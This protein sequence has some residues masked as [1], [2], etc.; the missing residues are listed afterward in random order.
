VGEPLV[1]VDLFSGPGGF[2]RG[3]K[4]AGWVTAVAVEKVATCV[5]TYRLNFPAVPVIGRD[6]REVT[7]GEVAGHLPMAAGRRREADL[8]TAGFPCETNS[9]AGTKSR[10]TYDHRLWLYRDAIRIARAVRA[11]SLLF[12]NV[13][14]IRTKKASEGRP[15]LLIDE[16]RRDLA[17]AGYANRSEFVLTASDFGV[18]QRRER[19]FLIAARE[20]G[21]IVVPEPPRILTTVRQA[22]ADLPPD[23]PSSEYLDTASRYSRLMRD[24]G[25]WRA[26]GGAHVL[27]QHHGPRHRPSTVARN[28]LVPRGRR[29]WDLYAEL[30]PGTLAG[31]QA[32]GVLPEVPFKQRGNRLALSRPSKTVTSHCEGELLHPT[33][34]RCLSVREAAR[35]QSFPDCHIFAGPTCTAHEGQAQDMYEQVGDAVPPLVAWSLGMAMRRMLAGLPEE[36]HPLSAGE[37]RNGDKMPG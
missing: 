25:F 30:D 3:L 37:P 12:E 18:P 23:L 31:L 9:T 28:A 13:V 7:G 14:P 15:E 22:F 11:R 8:V 35:L 1:H 19:W 27:T 34:N 10:N 33:R 21:N 20:G 6:I 36:V 17:D 16:I 26:E 4:A 29:L 2:G 24:R 32:H 5:Q